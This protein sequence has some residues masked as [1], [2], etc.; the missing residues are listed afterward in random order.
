MDKAAA[1]VLVSIVIPCRNE[2]GHV[3]ACL[4]AVLGFDFPKRSLEI[5]VVDGR[6]TDATREIVK[7]YI[8]NWPLIKLLDNPGMIVSTAMN[9]GIRA[10]SG[11]FIVRLDAHSAYPPGYL[12]DC[13]AL[14]ERTG[15][16][17]SGGRVVAVPNG[18]GP[19]A[20]PVA[21]ATGHRFGVGSGAFR[22]GAKPGFVD[23]VPFGTFRREIFDKVG[24][25]DERLTR[26][27]DNEFNDR[28]RRGGYRI[29]FDPAIKIYYKNQA[30][31][32]GLLHQ[33]FYTGLWNIYALALHP[34]TFKWRR[35]VPAVFVAYLLALP[36]A[37][38]LLPGPGVYFF[39]GLLYLFLNLAVSVTRP[40]PL[41]VRLR[42]AATFGSYHSAYGLGTFA[43]MISVASGFWK[44]HLGAPLVKVKRDRG[45]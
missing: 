45:V 10:A 40:Y 36:F 1:R 6:S 42:I 35:F 27:E 22:V 16:A 41:A 31:L 9:I 17:N 44:R 13:L 21:V 30:T 38:V 39:P 34:Y 4:E 33:S 19:W 25:F 8:S 43:G 20:V 11:K 18:S 37:Y 28:L 12:N 29:A 32:A 2:E 26:N 3:S 15:A 5:L 14:I 24:F 7:G 23:T